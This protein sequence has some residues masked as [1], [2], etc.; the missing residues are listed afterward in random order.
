MAGGRSD[1][2]DRADVLQL[3]KTAGNAT[4][5]AAIEKAAPHVNP[6]H[7]T[8]GATSVSSLFETEAPA[9][10]PLISAEQLKALQ[11]PYNARVSN[12]E[13][14]RRYHDLEKQRARDDY[15]ADQAWDRKLE[16]IWSQLKPEPTGPD[17]TT[18]PTALV[19]DPAILEAPL[20]DEKAEGDFRK[21]VFAELMKT[22][23]MTVR[24]ADRALSALERGDDGPS[25]KAEVLHSEGWQP[26]RP[27]IPRT[28]HQSP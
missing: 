27:P 15:P 23:T 28:G 3:Q 18:V 14:K 19:L 22:P 12:A 7:L 4:V 13:V 10:L 24:V 17:Q 25:T 26:L 6:S 5:S 8:K 21:L 11:D 2:L 16:H 1:V 9:L 20:G